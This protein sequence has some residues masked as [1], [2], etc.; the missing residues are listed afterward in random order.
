M[1]GRRHVAEEVG[2]GRSRNSPADGRRDMVVARGD[3]GHKRPQ[4][5]EGRLVAQPLLQLHVG[6]DL[7]ERHMPGA[8]HHHLHAGIPRAAREPADLDELGDLPGVRGVVAAAGAHGITDGDAHIVLVQDSQH[9]VVVLIEGVLATSGL[10]PGEDERPS[11]RYDIGESPRLFERLDDPAVYAGVNGDEIDPVLGVGAHHFQEILGRNGN[12]RLFQVAD[13]VVHGHRANHGRRFL[14]ERTA[15]GTCLAGVGEIHDGIGAQFQGH[16]HLLP[17]Q[18]LIGQIARDAEVHVHLRGKRHALQRGTD[19]GRREACVMDVGRDGDAP[20]GHGG[21]NGLRLAAL[22]GG[23]SGH[24]RRDDAGASEIDLS[25]WPNVA[26]CS[27]R[28]S[29]VRRSNGAGRL[30]V[31]HGNSLRWHYPYQVRR[32]GACTAPPL[33][34]PGRRAAASS[35]GIWLCDQYRKPTGA[36]AAETLPAC[37]FP[38]QC[39]P[40]FR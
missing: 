23:N 24:L 4:H 14:D 20:G 10:H 15:E 6:G 2:A 35:P 13:G 8:F 12:E 37:R 36:T 26:R 31:S 21:A 39:G 5:V 11:S 40:G 18:G 7:I 16:V 38:G 34:L 19:A 3:I 29:D 17:F 32:V 1:L 25:D 27:A 28:A 22:G 30:A 9:L 33:S